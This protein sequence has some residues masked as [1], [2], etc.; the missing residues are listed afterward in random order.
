MRSVP[1]WLRRTPVE[2]GAELAVASTISR[3]D[4][5]TASDLRS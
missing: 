2:A 3:L 1:P 5:L 4:S